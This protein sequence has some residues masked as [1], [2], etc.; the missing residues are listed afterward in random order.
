MAFLHLRLDAVW[1]LVAPQ[2]PLKPTDGMAPL[3]ERLAGAEA[4]ARTQPFRRR[5]WVTDIETRLG[6]VY[7]A[8]TIGVLKRRFSG[9]RFVWIMGADNLID[10]S[11]WERWDNIFR[12]VPVAV[13]A[14]PT[15]SL[16]AL[17]S[18]AARR[19]AKYRRRSSTA[20]DLAEADPPAWVFEHIPLSWESATDIRAGA[21]ARR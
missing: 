1:W 13:F 12:S 16:R 2:N 10:I 11:R 17:G 18:K 3:A 21:R 9:C 19:Y 14:R 6:T 4:L 8:D 20:R 7:T 5:V 15:Y